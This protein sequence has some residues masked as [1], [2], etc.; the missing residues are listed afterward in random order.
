VADRLCHASI[1]DAALLSRAA[2]HR[3]RHNDVEHLERLLAGPASRGACLVV[4][5]SVFSMDGDCAPLEDIARAAHARG[6]MLLVD[7]AHA[8]GI[9]GPAGSGLV[10]EAGLQSSVTVCMATLSKAFG[11]Y[12]GFV[13]CSESLRAWLINSARSF[14][15]STARGPA[16][17][18]RALAAVRFVREHPELGPE[19][20]RRADILR[21]RLHEAG[22]DTGRSASAI[23]PVMVGDNR[24][25]LGLSERLRAS[26]ILAIAIRPPTV[27]EGTARLRLSVTRAH[28]VEDIERAA[29]QIVQAAREES[30]L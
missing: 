24:R 19:L 14:I 6:A 29:R 18:A 5:E 17:G 22:L 26:G 30:V 10:R 1:V 13:T 28:T 25:T 20:L 11:G 4:T 12:G 16:V 3:F 23:I 7:E 21:N 9:F 2:V 8:T 15:Y 27:P